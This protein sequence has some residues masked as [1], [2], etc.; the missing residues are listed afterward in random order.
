[1]QLL[2]LTQ[3][4]ALMYE[5]DFFLWQTSELRKYMEQRELFIVTHLSLF[6]FLTALEKVN[7]G[8]CVYV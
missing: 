2:I 8:M 6:F 1:M 3:P 5:Y 7:V 4:Y